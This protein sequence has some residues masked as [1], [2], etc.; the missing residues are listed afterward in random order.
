[1]NR[2][3]LYIFRQLTIAFVFAASAVTFVILFTQ[4]FRLLTLVIDNSSTMW[5]FLNLMALSIPTFLPLVLPLGLG[6]AVLFV[7]HKLAIDSELIVM[8]A[9]G[10]S[11][12]RQAVPALIL[13]SF[14]LLFG[15]MLTLWITPTANRNLV[16]LE[17]HMRDNY[18]VLL[19]RPG[20]FNDITDGLTFYARARG[21]GG[22]LEGILMH[23]VRKPETPV[24]IM[25]DRGQVVDNN[26]QPQLVI[27][28]GRRQEMNEATGELSQLAFDQYVLDINALRSTGAP[29]LPDPREQTITELLN[30]SPQMLA[31]RASQGRLMAELHQRLSAPLLA[32][33]YTLIGLA[34]ILAGEFNRRGMSRRIFIAA[35]AIIAVQATTMSIN[36]M[37]GR[38]SWL[39][40]AFYIV[41]LAPAVLCF[42][43]INLERMRRPNESTS[44]EAIT[45]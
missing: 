21:S 31:E 39:A 26:G 22:A 36:S 9:V 41:V 18:A 33:S 44:P 40:F 27:F 14:V 28:D 19:T 37:I 24:T 29:R 15:Y 1:M 16:A 10:I 6:V 42:I 30:P 5:I 38:E 17:Y 4:S 11:P 20:N 23:D 34:A 13:T 2:L 12:M 8:R 7:Y 45:S 43:L 32:L 35:S 25:A 3:N